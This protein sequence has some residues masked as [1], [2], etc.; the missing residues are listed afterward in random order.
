MGN[1]GKVSSLVEFEI[2]RHAGIRNRVF[3]I[4]LTVYFMFPDDLVLLRGDGFVANIYLVCSVM[5]RLNSYYPMTEVGTQSIIR[6][7]RFLTEPDARTSNIGLKST[8]SDIV[9]VIGLT[10]YRHS[11]SDIRIFSCPCRCPRV[12][13]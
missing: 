5:S 13:L 9:S 8:E 12:C 3:R 2:L 11:I 10:F 1:W 6:A 4:Y 7:E